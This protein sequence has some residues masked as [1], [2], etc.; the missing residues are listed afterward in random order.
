MELRS[1]GLPFS[2]IGDE[3]TGPHSNKFCLCAYGLWICHCHK[4]PTGIAIC[5]PP[6][7]PY[8]QQYAMYG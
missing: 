5:D 6:R 4:N 2:I 3:C 7:V 8:I 1:K